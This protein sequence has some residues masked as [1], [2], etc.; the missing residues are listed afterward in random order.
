MRVQTCD[1]MW[2]GKVWEFIYI[3]KLFGTIEAF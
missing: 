3:A 1:E 2:A